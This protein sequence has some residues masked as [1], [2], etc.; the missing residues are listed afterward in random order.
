[1]GARRLGV[2]PMEWNL[3]PIVFHFGGK[4]KKATACENESIL[5]ISSNNFLS[6]LPGDAFSTMQKNSFGVCWVKALSNAADTLHEFS[7]SIKVRY[8]Q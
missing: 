1:M 2:R 7:K 6:T 4:I 8:A 5:S 3:K